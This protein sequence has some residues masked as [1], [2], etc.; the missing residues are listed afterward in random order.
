MTVEVQVLSAALQK[1]AGKKLLV[2]NKNPY[3]EFYKDSL[4]G[5][6]CTQEIVPDMM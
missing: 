4:Y 1:E 3:N 2:E 5:F 6:L